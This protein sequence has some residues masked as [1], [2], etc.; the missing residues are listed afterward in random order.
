MWRAVVVFT[1]LFSN[2]LVLQW[3]VLKLK[4][5]RHISW[6]FGSLKAQCIGHGG[7]DPW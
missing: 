3:G 7:E 4:K 2:S 6:S 1:N 5:N